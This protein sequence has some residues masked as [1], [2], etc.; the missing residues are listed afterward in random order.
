[1]GDIKEIKPSEKLS[2]RQI[3]IAEAWVQNGLHERLSQEEFCRRYSL[4]TATLA[5]WKNINIDFQ[6]YVNELKGSVIT[7]D[8]ITAFNVIKRDILKRIN[9]GNYT[10]TEREF[11]MKHFKH[12]I[13][14]ENQKAMDKLGITAS[15]ELTTK[16][17]EQRKNILLQRLKQD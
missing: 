12:V 9:T 7:G 4:S 14:Y 6:N 16:S 11:Y 5:K 8:E 17:V 2:H 13:D 3:K 10:D 1:M 15:G